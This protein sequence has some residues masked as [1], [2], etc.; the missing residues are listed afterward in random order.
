MTI[1]I[2]KKLFTPNQKLVG[3]NVKLLWI[4]WFL[5][6]MLSWIFWPSVMMP[7]P[8]EVWLAFHEMWFYDGLGEQLIISYQTQ[9]IAV[10][11]A[12]GIS[13]LIAYASVVPFFRPVAT[14]FS[15][16]RYISIG[17]LVT[18]FMLLITAD[19]H[20]IKLLLLVY[21]ISVFFVTSMLPVILDIPKVEFEHAR[22]LKMNEWQATWHVV[23]RGKVD[24]VFDIL[25]QN[26]AMGW[27]MLIMVEGLVRSE[28]GI[29]ALLVNQMKHFKLAQVMAIIIV[30]LISGF[31]QDRALWL[32]RKL[33][34][35]YAD[36]SKER[37]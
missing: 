24:V 19:G 6:I 29:G 37:T 14:M 22:T 34:C 32:L 13:L 28:G 26:S 9:L 8:K 4:F 1:Q 25:R 33:L 12:T 5:V 11:I 10:L 20:Y 21:G 35:P 7:S 15:T 31:I 27:M 23:I 16:L 17:A 36:L 3:S 18:F 2:V 30:L